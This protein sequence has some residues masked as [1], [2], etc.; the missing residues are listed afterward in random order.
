MPRSA[1]I[2]FP[3]AKHHVMNRGARG[4]NVFLDESYCSQFLLLMSRAVERYG[5]R[6]HGFAIMPNH[7]HLMVESVEGNLGEAMKY[8]TSQYGFFLNAEMG[9]DGQ[10]FRG[11]YKNKPV[12][13]EQHWIYL[14]AYLHLNPVRARLVHE[15]EDALWT[16]H[17][18]YLGRGRGLDWLTTEDLSEYFDTEKGTYPAYCSFDEKLID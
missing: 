12:Y 8:V 1:R 5:I 18:A 6:V 2:D 17:Q 7:F 11:R 10:V 13:L 15:P 14:L 16:S 4:E 9:W 3:G